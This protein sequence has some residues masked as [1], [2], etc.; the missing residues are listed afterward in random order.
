MVGDNN[1]SSYRWVRDGSSLT[2]QRWANIYE[3]YDPAHRCVMRHDG[4]NW[5][6]VL[7]THHFAAIC[8]ADVSITI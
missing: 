2:Y 1:I 4:G 6:D 7:C 5:D 3:P 8:E